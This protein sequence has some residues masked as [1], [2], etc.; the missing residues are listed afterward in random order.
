MSYRRSMVFFI[1]FNR[2]LWGTAFVP[3]LQ[4]M[5]GSI[6]SFWLSPFPHQQHRWAQVP[7]RDEGRNRLKGKKKIWCTE[8][9]EAPRGQARSGLMSAQHTIRLAIYPPLQG[10]RIHSGG[11]RDSEG[12]I[13]NS[14]CTFNS[15]F[16]FLITYL[17]IHHISECLPSFYCRV[18][19]PVFWPSNPNS[20]NNYP[21]WLWWRW[22][23]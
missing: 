10:K 8:P 11:E 12:G 3:N 20:S 19:V 23:R 13:K 1:F 4:Y 5:E 9:P 16:L 7:W 2:G 17:F 21:T 14:S 15:V 22:R 18:I 6:F